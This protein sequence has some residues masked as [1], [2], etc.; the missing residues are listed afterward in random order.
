MAGPAVRVAAKAG[1]LNHSELKHHRSAQMDGA[2]M[3]TH[4][5]PSIS[6]RHFLVSTSLAAAV[7][8]LDP[9]HAFAEVDGLVATA[10]KEGAESKITLQPLRGE[11]ASG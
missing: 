9:R 6:R 5:D 3:I 7:T 10:R 1:K 11:V 8:L 4:T 2:A